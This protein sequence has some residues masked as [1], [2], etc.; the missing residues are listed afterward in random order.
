[1]ERTLAPRWTSLGSTG[2]EWGALWRLRGP[3]E[4]PLGPLW[5]LQG[6]ILVHFGTP[7]A[8]WDLSGLY[9]DRF[10]YT[11]APQGTLWDLFGL[12]LGLL[13]PSW[14]PLGL[15]LA[16]SGA[17]L[18]LHGALLSSLLAT[19]GSKESQTFKK[20]YTNPSKS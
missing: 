9:R 20:S 11:L 6:S 4:G 15:L 2:V 17:P 19:W 10:W 8:L 3:S 18:A 5:V 14:A 16:A 12:N 1:M 13:G 7:R